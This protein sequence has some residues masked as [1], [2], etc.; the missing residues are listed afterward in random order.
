MPIQAANV[1]VLVMLQRESIYSLMQLVQ[2]APQE[3]FKSYLRL[4]AGDVGIAFAEFSENEE[5]LRQRIQQLKATLDEFL[6][7]CPVKECYAER[8]KGAI[9]EAN[10]LMERMKK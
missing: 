8:N 3:I 7:E 9:D 4:I 5:E 6:A 10:K 2:E 1:A